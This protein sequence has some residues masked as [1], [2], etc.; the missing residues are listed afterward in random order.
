MWTGFHDH[1][2]GK[3]VAEVCDICVGVDGSDTRSFFGRRRV[4]GVDLGVGEGAAGK[5]YVP[6]AHG[7][8]VVG[9]SAFALD[10]GR[11]LPP[12]DRATEC[13]C[14][15]GHYSPSSQSGGGG[16]SPLILAPAYSTALTML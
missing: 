8:D 11:V 14:R 5:G 3:K 12:T 16:S 6:G 2:L 9:V 13:A 7:S 1:D 4:D 15:G 10:K